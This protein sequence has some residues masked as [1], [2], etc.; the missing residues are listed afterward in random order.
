[1]YTTDI[2][3]S[4]CCVT[5][6]K[7]QSKSTVSCSG[8]GLSLTHGWKKAWHT[9]CAEGPEVSHL[10]IVKQWVQKKACEDWN[11]T[12]SYDTLQHSIIYNF[13]HLLWLVFIIIWCLLGLLW[14]L[15]LL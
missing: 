7:I 8:M 11:A 1:M 2:G 12:E 15:R 14:T 9:Q 10:E 3:K 4:T 5:C 13:W 6:N